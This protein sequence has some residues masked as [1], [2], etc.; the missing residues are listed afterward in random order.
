M[1]FCPSPLRLPPRLACNVLW[2]SYR[3]S[4]GFDN[5]IANHYSLFSSRSA[6]SYGS[7]EGSFHITCDLV[8]LAQFR[9][10]RANFDADTRGVL[11]AR[12]RSRTAQREREGQL[13]VARKTLASSIFQF[14]RAAT[15]RIG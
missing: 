4:P 5:N 11:P 12:S 8:L 14:A 15:A 6:G 7:H 10:Q 3:L 9:R 13:L 1:R 2:S